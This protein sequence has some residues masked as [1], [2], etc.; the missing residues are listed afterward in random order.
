MDETCRFAQR[1]G[2]FRRLTDQSVENEK[3]YQKTKRGEN[4]KW[5]S[6]V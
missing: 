1:A 4:E 2:I 6:L 5:Q 3:N